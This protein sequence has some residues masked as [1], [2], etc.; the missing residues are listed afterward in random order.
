MRNLIENEATYQ[1]S[2][3]HTNVE[4]WYALAASILGELT[5]DKAMSRLDV[6]TQNKH[7]GERNEQP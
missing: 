2:G 4:N 1:P 7:R 3:K 6:G 5:P